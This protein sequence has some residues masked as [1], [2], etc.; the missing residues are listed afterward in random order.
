[1]AWHE[2]GWCDIE[3][4]DGPYYWINEIGS[5]LLFDRDQVADL[6]DKKNPYPRWDGEVPYKYAFFTNE[7]GLENDRN[8]KFNYWSY[9]PLELESRVNALPPLSYEERNIASI[10]LGSVENETQEY[11]RN[12]FKDWGGSIDEYY[13]A[14]KLNK[15]EKAKYTF[16]K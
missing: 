12:K 5:I 4:H 1:M 9:K 8:L 2:R 15:K 10:F 16:K 11:F 3:H 7:Y 6:K 14:D 13:V